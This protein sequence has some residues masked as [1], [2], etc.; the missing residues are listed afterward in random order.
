MNPTNHTLA[1]LH[2]IEPNLHALQA[3]FED[4]FRLGLECGAAVSVWQGGRE[5]LSLTGGHADGARSMA[6]SPKTL[7]LTWSATKGPAAATLLAVCQQQQVSLQTPVAA[8]WPEFAAAG[9]SGLR[10][11]D[12]LSH[13]AGLFALQDHSP[14]F[15][16]HEAVVAALAAQPPLS[17]PGAAHAYGPR[18]FGYLLDELCRR[19]AG[20][21]LGALWRA[22]IAD[23]LN[24]DFWIGLP[25]SEFVRTAQILAPKLTATIGEK[26]E[27][28]E[29]LATAGSPTQA[30]FSTPAG[31][32]TASTMNR[33]EVRKASFPAFGGIGS[34]TALAKFYALLAAGGSLDG[35]TI[36]EPSTIRRMSERLS[37]GMDGVLHRPT[38]FSAGFMLDP[39]D[40][41][42]KKIRELFGPSGDAFGHPGAGGSLAFA[43]PAHDLAFAYVMNQMEPGALP[44]ERALRLVRAMYSGPQ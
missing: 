27:F 30:A 3:A 23:P 25:E 40:E 2:R 4:N 34:A 22:L 18:A 10:I 20:Q 17:A 28:E 12:V 14:R 24:L 44:R 7:V 33:A 36:F 37:D 21:P 9:K 15:T 43:D 41:A 8:F 1:P 6:W 39:L 5:V 31:M 29:A 42:G 13:R 35:I 26:T 11:Q 38:A 19:I 32:L 16:D